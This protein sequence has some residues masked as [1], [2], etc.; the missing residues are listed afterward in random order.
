MENFLAQMKTFWAGLTS[1]QRL[2]LI[3]SAVGVLLG[4]LFFVQYSTRV[5]YTNL[6]TNLDDPSEIG[7]ITTILENWRQPYKIDGTNIKV[8]VGD[9]DRIR[10]R[11][12][13][14]KIAP[15]GGI[16]GFEIFDVT[17]LA[18][19]DYER[20]INY[21]R[22]LQGEL[23]R[24]I[25][26][27]EGIQQ[28]RVL[29]TIPKEELYI[30]KQVPPTA[31]IKLTLA[32]L[33]TLSH[34]QIKGILYL[35][36]SAV[37]GLTPENVTVV[38]NKG[39]L[40][41]E[42]EEITKNQETL[43]AKQLEIQRLEGEKLEKNIRQTLASV[44]NPDRVE[45]IVKWEMDFDRMETKEESYS[46]P[47]FEQL[48]VS[49]EETQETFKGEGQKPG[50]APGVESQ[51]P[52]YKAATEGGG[53][54]EYAKT[55][56]RT[57]YLSDKKDVVEVKTPTISKISVGVFIDGTYEYDEKGK[58]KRDKAGS[59]NY[60]PVTPPEMIKYENLVWAAIGAQ[61]GK[62]Y[63]DR[64]YIVNVENV[65]FDR[66]SQWAE[67]KVEESAGFKNMLTSLGTAGAILLVVVIG[68]IMALAARRRR[69][70][71]EEENRRR[72]EELARA[73]MEAE[74]IP[75][76]EGTP[77]SETK[78]LLLQLINKEPA[79]IAEIARSYFY[80]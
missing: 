75:G 68:I 35:V 59:A 38:D 1:V 51:M 6:Y 42:I 17:R 57:N 60:Q 78:M 29:L 25:K 53:P 39:V 7:K 66:T 12:A 52:E 26:S 31:S 34:T 27:I 48:K 62:E 36:A 80:A 63:L 30:E 74:K 14:E 71:A 54:T 10:L 11:L 69:L 19:T 44:L 3:G 2:T 18:M 45:V 40:L 73:A 5:E 67:E 23:S 4:L 64:E 58:I 77:P 47:G 76:L 8:P 50:G 20:R 13:A 70:T 49:E 33:T 61:K 22:A 46:M 41:S 9:K 72:E 65:Q 28:A 56:R 37:E 43:T 79:R 15:T 16:V 32:P 21:L 24:T 55:D